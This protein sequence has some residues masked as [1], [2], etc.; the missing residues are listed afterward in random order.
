MRKNIGVKKSDFWIEF[1]DRTK[2]EKKFR[3]LKEY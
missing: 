3:A 1:E 2:S